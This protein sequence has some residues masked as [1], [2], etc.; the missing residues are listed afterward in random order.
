[1]ARGG[2]RKYKTCAS[3]MLVGYKALLPPLLHLDEDVVHLGVKARELLFD[4]RHPIP[5]LRHLHLHRRELLPHPA[6]AGGQT[7]R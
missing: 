5:H 7:P 2:E 1:M 4:R 3:W 6:P